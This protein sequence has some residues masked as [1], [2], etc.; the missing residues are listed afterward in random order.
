MA[1]TP[2]GWTA[3][4]QPKSSKD[5]PDTEALEESLQTVSR[6]CRDAASKSFDA[7][8]RGGHLSNAHRAEA[9][10]A[11][12]T[13]K[14]ANLS[15]QL[16][17]PIYEMPTAVNLL[18]RVFQR[19]AKAVIGKE[20]TV[21]AAIYSEAELAIEAAMITLGEREGDLVEDTEFQTL[22]SMWMNAPANPESAAATDSEA[23]S[24][25]ATV[26]HSPGRA[27]HPFVKL[28]AFSPDA[29]ETA[30]QTDPKTPPKLK[31]SHGT[32]EKWS[33][34]MSHP[35]AGSSVCSCASEL[36]I[37]FKAIHNFQDEDR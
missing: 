11:A 12:L 2:S 36:S 27:S 10:L 20:T 15:Q 7:N 21:R 9:T 14:S 24:W 6:I 17:S 1:L 13:H 3:P 28:H 19:V 18:P 8:V 16:N 22:C 33:Q 5:S 35:F 23:N 37:R 34:D 25:L 4:S 32:W 26:H 31:P 30:P 29:P